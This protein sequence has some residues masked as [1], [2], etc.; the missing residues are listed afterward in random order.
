MN[1]LQSKIL[2]MDFKKAAKRFVLLSLLITVLGG[3]LTGFMFRAQISEV[4]TYHQTYENNRENG[5][6]TDSEKNTK[7]DAENH[8]DREREHDYEKTGLFESGQFTRPT[9]GARIVFFTYAALCGLIAIA[10]W[11]LV[12]M[13][14][15]Q[16]AA[17]ASMNR[18]LWTIL[19]LFFNLAAVIAFLI[20]RSLQTVCPSCGA[21]Q[22][23][24]AFCR[25]CGTPL[26]IKCTECGVLADGKD[27]YCSHCGKQITHENADKIK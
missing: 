10:Y 24:A 14:L 22:K 17:K 12:M 15:Y 5:M 20:V 9:V 7:Y 26:Q 6:Q 19:G 25:A 16:A 18:T 21:Y 11:L 4:I 27:N 2:N 13:W 1:K 8:N 23:S 3:A